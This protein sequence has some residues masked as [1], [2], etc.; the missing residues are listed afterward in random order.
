VVPDRF[1][2][3]NEVDALELLRAALWSTLIV[4]GPGVIAA[5]VIGIVIALMQALTQIQEMTL[6]FVPKIIAILIATTIAAPLMGSE[7][8]ALTNM[9]FLRIETGF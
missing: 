6:T 9:A 5:M 1:N 3:V 8:M 4:S 2:P 7:L